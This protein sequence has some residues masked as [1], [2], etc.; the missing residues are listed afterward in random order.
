MSYVDLG[1]L[2]DE[3][4]ELENSLTDSNSE[5]GPSD[6]ARLTLLLQLQEDLGHGLRACSEEDPLLIAK[7]DWE[8][9]CKDSAEG[10]GYVESYKSN[11]L[12][13][14]I[15]WSSWADSCAEDCTEIEFEGSTYIYRNF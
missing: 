7:E 13:A 2:A 5:F 12:I 9:Y 6:Q 15:N 11:P 10:C 14:H 3:L 8:D 4:D 1:E